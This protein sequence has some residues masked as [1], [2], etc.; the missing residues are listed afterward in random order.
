MH[1]SVIYFRW[2]VVE[3]RPACQPPA[4][5]MCS[6]AVSSIY[7][8][9]ETVY[10]QDGVWSLFAGRGLALVFL[11][12]FIAHGSVSRIR[13]VAPMCTPSNS[14]VPWHTRVFIPNCISIGSSV[15]AGL[16]S[17]P[18]TLQTDRGMCGMCSN[19]PH[20]RDACYAR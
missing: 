7:S 4:P 19:V 15:F 3:F 8:L 10:S 13:Q 1:P 14:V 11:L 18:D 12:N 5:A 20:V 17:V 2:K 6:A 9:T 16:T